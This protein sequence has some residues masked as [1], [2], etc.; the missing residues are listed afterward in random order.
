MEKKPDTLDAFMQR[1]KL[2]YGIIHSMG[3]QQRNIK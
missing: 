3:M 1:E 2:N